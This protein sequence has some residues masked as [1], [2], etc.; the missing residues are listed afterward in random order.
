M[1]PNSELSVKNTAISS[2]DTRNIDKSQL[3]NSEFIP[4]LLIGLASIP[5]VFENI[6]RNLTETF[7]YKKYPNHRLEIRGNY[8]NYGNDGLLDFWF[9]LFQRS[10]LIKELVITWIPFDLVNFELFL[11]FFQILQQH[12]GYVDL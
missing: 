7:Y 2:K 3:H 6:S 9:A 11:T 12:S 5:T 4:E 1:K 10:S 8:F